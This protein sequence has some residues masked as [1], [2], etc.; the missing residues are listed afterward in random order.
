MDRALGGE[1][2]SGL[3]L[4]GMAGVGKTRLAREGLGMAQRRGQ[5]TAWA[6]ATASGTTIP[7]GALAHLLPPLQAAHQPSG[8]QLLQQAMATLGRSGSGR[9]L[10][11]GI[12]DAHLLDDTSATLI[13]QIALTG[14]ASLVVTLR[15]GEPAPDAI[16]SLWKDGLLGRLEV[17]PLSR[18]ELEDLLAAVLGGPVATATLERLWRLTRGNLLFLREVVDCAWDAAE[19]L[20]DEGV[21]RW[22]ARFVPGR[23][24][25]ELIEAR[26]GRLT[27]AER[28]LVELLA[29]GE[30]LGVSLAAEL[31]SAEAVAGAERRGVVAAQDAG[32]RRELRLAHPLYSE[33]VRAE[34]TALRARTVQ[35][36]LCQA[37]NAKLRRRGDVLRHVGLQLE[38]EDPGDPKVFIEAAGQAIVARNLPLAERSA[39]AALLGDGG[40]RAKLALASALTWQNRMVEA[41]GILSEARAGATTDEEHASVAL[42]LAPNL[43]WAQGRVD[44][45][46]CV[47]ASAEDAI[48]DTA[49]ALGLTAVRAAFSLF[50]G[51]PQVA[52]ELASRTL[53]SPVVT[54]DSV[55]W[56]AAALAMTLGRCGQTADAMAAAMRGWEA[57]QS[58]EHLSMAYA[59]AALFQ[60]EITSRWAAGDLCGAESRANEYHA[61]CLNEMWTG[62]EL[63]AACLLVGQT[64]LIRGHPVTAAD[65]LREADSE[66]NGIQPSCWGAWCKLALTEALSISGATIERPSAPAPRQNGAALDTTLVLWEPDALLAAAWVAAAGGELSRALSLAEQAASKAFATGQLAVEA[67]AIHTALRFDSPTRRAARLHEIANV[68]GGRLVPAFAAHADALDR[69]DGDELNRVS[70]DFEAIGSDLLAAEAAVHSSAAYAAAGRRSSSLAS[71]VRAQAVADRCEGARTPALQL[72]IAESLRLTRREREV[73]GLA[74]RGHS[75]RAIAERLLISLRT[76]EGHLDKVFTKLGVNRRGELAAVFAPEEER[77]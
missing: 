64:A 31:S 60:C 16:T 9:P 52:I 4:A 34:T 2:G 25:S 3:I 71:A 76:V 59:R 6:V 8:L 62:L 18:L 22:K 35:R 20:D 15:T 73:A 40:F 30:P 12:D 50:A 24:L 43:F 33:V 56:G 17:Q 65:W 1:R 13:H 39:R 61:R 67:V 57:L 5:R 58:S 44:E 54:A 21:W 51:R 55:V 28:T 11:L 7:F 38:I 42:L 46:E 77:G 68:V 41:E 47:L 63:G 27:A 14:A 72:G 49:V 19:L 48:A 23:R 26:L 74:A 29:F 10:V 69:A 66:L 37:G 75:N 70:A 45:A 32:R 53:A 36:L